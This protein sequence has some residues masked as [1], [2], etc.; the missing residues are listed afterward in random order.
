MFLHWQQETR[1]PIDALKVQAEKI[2]SRKIYWKNQ[3]KMFSNDGHQNLY[4]NNHH[5][6]SPKSSSASTNEGAGFVKFSK[7]SLNAILNDWLTIFKFSKRRILLPVLVRK[8][9]EIFILI[10]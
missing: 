9:D 7:I 6:L 4:L 8:D 2:I 1:V 3:H 5:L 10:T